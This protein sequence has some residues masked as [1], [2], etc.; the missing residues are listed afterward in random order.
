MNRSSARCWLPLLN[1]PL[2]DQSLTCILIHIWLVAA[3][4]GKQT[5]GYWL[6]FPRGTSVV[7]SSSF[8]GRHQSRHNRINDLHYR[9]FV[10]SGSLTTKEPQVFVPTAKARESVLEFPWRQGRYLAR[11]GQTTRVGIIVNLMHVAASLLT[12]SLQQLTSTRLWIKYIDIH[13]CWL[14]VDGNPD[15]E[16]LHWQGKVRQRNCSTEFPSYISIL[17]P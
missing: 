7:L 10:T 5:S 3:A 15:I 13:V 8:R 4:A 6:P 17:C 9:A 11:N 12:L 2:R 14:C 1:S 16:C